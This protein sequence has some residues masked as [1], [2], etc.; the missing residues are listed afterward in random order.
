MLSGT[1]RFAC[2]LACGVE[3]PLHSFI[4]SLPSRESSRRFFASLSSV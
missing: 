1:G 4:L 2:E 3:A